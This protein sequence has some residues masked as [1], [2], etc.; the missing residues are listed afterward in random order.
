MR[1]N[2]NYW[3]RIFACCIFLLSLVGVLRSQQIAQQ[4][5]YFNNL[6][7]INPAFGGIDR[8]LSIT[9]H[10][11]S[12]W[13]GIQENPTFFYL[14]ATIPMYIWK[15][16]VGME[17]FQYSHGIFKQ[18]K[19]AFSYNYVSVTS[20]GLL[21]IGAKLGMHRLL[22][23]GN[24]IRTPEGIYQ[25]GGI[26]HN[27]P[28]LGTS[29]YSSIAPFVDFGLYFDNNEVRSG[30]SLRQTPEFSAQPGN[31]IFDQN[32]E[33]VL[34]SVYRMQIND[35]FFFKPSALVK[36]DFANIQTDINFNFEM[37]GNIFGGIGLR[38]YQSN[39]LD[40]VNITGGL[41]LSDNYFV[42]Y[43]YDI[44]LSELKYVN[45]GSHELIFNYNL[46]KPI[47]TGIVPR[48]IHNPRD[49]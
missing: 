17:M 12:Q 5:Q 32:L 34:F 4:T 20:L 45:E 31:S 25:S 39:S 6:Y 27:D 28:S 46:N 38:G 44:G 30:I 48:A 18:S 23:D 19:L 15:G 37:N 16:A 22:I 1:S 26:V 8:S 35:K 21:S 33:A 7:S 9:T 11:R 42:S 43:S 3:F 36:Y 49:L 10:Y 47:A 14:G 2:L 24:L 29:K 13:D 41:K 40:A